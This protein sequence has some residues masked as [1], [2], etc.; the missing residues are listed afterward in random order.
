M[1]IVY[2]GAEHFMVIMRHLPTVQLELLVALGFYVHCSA[3]LRMS[4]CMEVK[5][6]V[7][8]IICLHNYTSPN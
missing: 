1:T 5:P 2:I 8:L 6:L 7:T 3:C 4:F